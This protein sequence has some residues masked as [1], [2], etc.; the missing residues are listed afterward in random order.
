MQHLVFW[1]HKY[2]A[3]LL[4]SSSNYVT[5]THFVSLT[6]NT[7]PSLEMT[8]DKVDGVKQPHYPKTHIARVV[9]LKNEGVL[10]CYRAKMLLN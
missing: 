9:T 4:F 5:V 10:P 2:F 3:Y 1:K 6:D 7:L 8:L